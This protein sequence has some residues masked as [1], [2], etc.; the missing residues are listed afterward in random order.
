M[1]AHQVPESVRILAPC[2]DFVATLSND[3]DQLRLVSGADS[4][5]EFAERW[6][7]REGGVASMG[8]PAAPDA[9][10]GAARTLESTPSRER[11][12][13]RSSIALYGTKYASTCPHCIVQGYLEAEQCCA[14]Y[15]TRPNWQTRA[16]KS[17]E[18]TMSKIGWFRARRKPVPR[19]SMIGRQQGV[20]AVL[21]GITEE[22]TLLGL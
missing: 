22:P 6:P 8:A 11:K 2:V 17:L 3:D 1:F 12:L 18:R 7:H 14:C 19:R 13:V 5:A 9:E 15:V 16:L 21:T 20:G 4:W 10:V